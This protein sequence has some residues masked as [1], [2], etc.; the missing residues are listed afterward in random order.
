MK[1]VSPVKCGLM[2]LYYQLSSNERVK[3]RTNKSESERTM[4]WTNEQVSEQTDGHTHARTH[5]RAHDQTNE[6]TN[7]RTGEQNQTLRRNNRKELEITKLKQHLLSTK[8]LHS[9]QRADKHK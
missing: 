3:E 6:H 9:K 7:E 5:A 2:Y 1:K 4:V 8:D